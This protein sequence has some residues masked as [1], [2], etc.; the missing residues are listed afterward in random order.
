MKAQRFLLLSLLIVTLLPAKVEAYQL[1]SPNG[2]ISIEVD[3]KGKIYYSVYF[4]GERVMEASPLSLLLE[5][6]HLGANPVVIKQRQTIVDEVLTTVWGGRNE[7]RDNYNQLTLDFQGDY[8]VEFRAYDQGVAYRFVTNLKNKQVTV[9]N[10]EVSYRFKFGVSAWMSD[11]KSYESNFKLIPLDGENIQNFNNSRDK[12]FLPVFVQSTPTVKVGITEANLHNYPSL[13]LDRGNDYENFLN[14]TFEKYALTTRVGG[15]SN[16]SKLTDKEADY[17]AVTSGAR[18]YPWR[19]MVISDDD[20]T[21]ANCDLVY[22]LSNPCTMGNTDWIKPGKVA[23]D[24]WHDY[25]VKGTDFDGGINTRTYLYEIDFA[26]KYGV[27]YILVDWMWTDKYDLSVFNPDVDMK[28]IIDYGKS[29]NVGVIVWCPGHTLHEQLEKTVELFS[30]MG[31]AG[32]KADFFGR[33]DQSGIQMYEDIAKA[34]FKGKLLI[35]F[36]GCTKPTGLSRTYPNIINYEAVLGNEYNKLTKNKCTISHKV[37]LA[38]TR[39][40]IGQMDFTPGGMRN[41][42]DKAEIFFTLPQVYGTRAGEMALYVIYDEP[43]KMLCDAPSAYEKEPEIP[44]FISKIPTI[45]DNTIV[46]D[47]AFNEYIVKARKS[48]NT[49]YI[50]GLNG[51]ESRTYTLDLSFLEPG[52]YQ[53]EILKDGVN[54]ARIGTDYELEQLEVDKKSLLDI[55]MV[56]GGGFTIR[57]ETK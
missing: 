24:W 30:G 49:W 9:K 26:A 41:R 12:I 27:E 20:R 37:N 53:A 51:K 15:F 32:I 50:S 19:L 57:I 4:K 54:A 8:S 17:I 38:F 44:Q 11:T 34:T 31:I 55:K 6:A 16:Y 5:N 42:N 13:F 2:N 22:Q 33:E 14:G 35:D 48:G 47:G 3:L 18:E 21:F 39:G 56:S 1:K 10:E 43:L 52:T 28:K 46:L 40:M 45:W 29:K 7:I 23:W 25:A 36:H